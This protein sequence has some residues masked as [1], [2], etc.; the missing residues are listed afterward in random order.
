MLVT[1]Y[2][3]VR[4][5]WMDLN[6]PLEFFA[7]F[8]G[9]WIYIGFMVGQVSGWGQLSRY[10]RANNPFDGERWRLRSGRMRFLTG[11]NNCLTIGANSQGLYLAML[12]LFRIGHPSLFIP[13][14]DISVKTGKT[15][16]WCWTEFH[17]R[18]APGVYLRVFGKLGQQIQSAA[19]QF[20]PG[21][22]VA[23]QDQF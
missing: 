19:G 14:Q 6:K 5:L 2:T 15:L 12:L 8:L 21:Q 7:F 10:Y 23:Q 11:Y 20:W 3:T 9:M 1:C 22:N 17:F 13:W 4:S 18:Q 16:L